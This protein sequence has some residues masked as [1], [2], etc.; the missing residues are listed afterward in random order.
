MATNGESP[1]TH[2]VDF[3]YKRISTSVVF[4]VQSVFLIINFCFRQCN[5]DIL[6]EYYVN[7]VRTH[8]GGRY[9]ITGSQSSPNILWES[10]D[11]DMDSGQ[12]RPT[13]PADGPP[14]PH[15][16]HHQLRFPPSEL[17][18]NLVEPIVQ[19]AIVAQRPTVAQNMAFAAL[20][21]SQD[22]HTLSADRLNRRL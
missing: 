9:N 10:D 16:P 3:I 8:S 15:H 2:S 19:D 14:Y 21:Q 17:S 6:Q 1:F 4:Q 12:S 11:Q 22:F 20:Q 5:H 18:A 13:T 7:L